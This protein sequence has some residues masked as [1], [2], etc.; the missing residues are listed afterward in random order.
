M[1]VDVDKNGGYLIECRVAYRHKGEHADDPSN[2]KAWFDGRVR[3]ATDSKSAACITASLVNGTF[4]DMLLVDEQ[5]TI[6]PDDIEIVH[7]SIIRI[8]GYVIP[9]HMRLSLI[10][11]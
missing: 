10:G 3:T 4:S 5:R 6:T 9:E 7:V 11:G 1:T 8:I 2:A